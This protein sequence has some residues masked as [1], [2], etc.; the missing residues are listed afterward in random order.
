MPWVL[1]VPRAPECSES[2]RSAAAFSLQPNRQMD[3]T[4]SRIW[5]EIAARPEGPLALRFYLQP[6]MATAL[7]IRDGVADGR[8][9]RPPYFWA[10]FTQPDQRAALVRDGWHSLWKLFTIA[11]VLDLAYQIIVLKGLR[12]L[13]GLLVAVVLAFVP[14]LMLRGL[15]NRLVRRTV[16]APPP[17]PPDH[18][19]R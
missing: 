5:Q 3:D 2:T 8:M 17:H 12:P 15:V 18:A 9:G 19:V 11:V 16:S 10:L 4:L 7:A 13:E 6:L 1:S 14:Y